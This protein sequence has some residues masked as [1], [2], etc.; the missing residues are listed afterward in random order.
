MTSH[1]GQVVQPHPASVGISFRQQ[2][3]LIGVSGRWLYPIVALLGLMLLLASLGGWSFSLLAGILAIV[4]G[5][6]WPTI[7]WHREAPS[8]R[9]YH[10][11]LPV[12]RTAHDLMRVLVGLLYLLAIC[13]VLG[14]IGA[15]GDGTLSYFTAGGPQAWAGFFLIPLVAFVL[16]TPLALWSDYPVTRRLLTGFVVFGFVS[17]IAEARG[18]DWFARA[19]SFLLAD[20]RWS[21]AETLTGGVDAMYR[22]HAGMS[23]SPLADWII[24]PAIWT[25]GG[26]VACMFA[27]AFRPDDLKRRFAGRARVGSADPT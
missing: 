4:S 24:G 21:F 7:L 26:V 25:V 8:Q 2:L 15:I 11:S 6:M 16:M 5:A 27:A 10:W 23:P 19:M 9:V 14:V 1:D 3:M 18:F 17:V 22:G 12:T 13:A 20:G